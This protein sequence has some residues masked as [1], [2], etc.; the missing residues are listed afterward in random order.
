MPSLEEIQ[1]QISDFSNAKSIFSKKEIK[2]LPEI[3]WEGE[4]VK[5]AAQG[6]YNLATGLLVATDKRLIFIDK[7]FI[8]LKVETF[9]Y[10][11]I[12]SIEYSTGLIFGEIVIYASG[13]KAKIKNMEKNETKDMAE[14][15]RE[16]I[17]SNNN[18]ETA[19]QTNTN[20]DLMA[21]LEK[22]SDL[23]NK[24]II[25]EDEFKTMKEK[26]IAKM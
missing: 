11:K 18:Q 9:L 3:L 10:D 14:F 7:G 12:S 19:K 15:V 20:N 13:N 1:N 25:T 5:K 17:Q 23:K 2:V 4:K 16:F 22:I 8:N 21:E 24:G 26:I 6:T